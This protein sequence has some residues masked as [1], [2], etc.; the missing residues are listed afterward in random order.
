MGE[1]GTSVWLLLTFDME[2]LF[3]LVRRALVILSCPLKLD[4]GELVWE[5]LPLI[6]GILVGV[7]FSLYDP[8][9]VAADCE[10]ASALGTGGPPW[11]GPTEG[12][13]AM[14]GNCCLVLRSDASEALDR[15]LA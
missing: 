14:V 7:S 12:D 1:G 13:P 11:T 4:C 6:R 2:L 5:V 15:L 3:K 10:P 8:L 9:R